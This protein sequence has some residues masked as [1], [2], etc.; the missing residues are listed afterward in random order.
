MKTASRIMEQQGINQYTHCTSLRRRKTAHKLK[1]LARHP[2]KKRRNTQ[3]SI[4][5][6]RDDIT[7]DASYTKKIILSTIIIQKNWIT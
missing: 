6:E 2:P 5:N 4:I 1:T 3:I 7:T